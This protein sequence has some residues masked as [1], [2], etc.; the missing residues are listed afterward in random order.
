MS[1]IYDILLN[2]QKEY[3]D[4]YEWNPN[5]EI[6][7]IRKIPLFLIN[8]SDFEVLKNSMV[9]FDK[10]FC[11]KIFNRT[12]RVKKINITLLNYAFLVSDG[13]RTMAVKLSKNGITS[14][15][16]ALLMEE[17]EEVADVSTD[18]KIYDLNYKIVKTHNDTFKTRLEQ[19][20]T[21]R[22]LKLLTNL[23]NHKE[24]NKICFLYLDCFEKNENNVN[25][26]F[27]K[28]NQEIKNGGTNTGKIEDFFKLINQK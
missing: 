2:F 21:E 25:I 26:A 20:K 23:Y 4:F 9:Q 17:N 7:H 27:E 5:D 1:Y 15:K 12:E 18:L 10:N 22:L 16:S 28:L 13:N 8:K 3:Y 11:E 24:D 19:E 6:I 14:H